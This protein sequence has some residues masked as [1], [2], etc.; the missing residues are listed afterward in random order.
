[1]SRMWL[2]IQAE[3][4]LGLTKDLI[5]VKSVVILF[6]SHI[7]WRNTKVFI[8]KKCHFVAICANNHFD[9]KTL[10]SLIQNVI[11][12]SN[13]HSVWKNIFT[14]KISWISHVQQCKETIEQSGIAWKADSSIKNSE[15]F[16]HEVVKLENGQLQSTGT[17]VEYK[18]ERKKGSL[19]IFYI[20]LFWSEYSGEKMSDP[21]FTRDIENTFL[22]LCLW[23]NIIFQ[24]RTHTWNAFLV[25]GQ[26]KIVTKLLHYYQ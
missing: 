23:V 9:W 7:I 21:L 26:N 24:I 8:L 3:T 13:L 14:H 6:P 20:V 4:S 12:G 15:L 18:K 11:K 25:S 10:W 17:V 2:H 5:L 22:C 19:K 1:M 16:S